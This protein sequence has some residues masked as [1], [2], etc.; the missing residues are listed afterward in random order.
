M[1]VTGNIGQKASPAM[2]MRL[3]SDKTVYVCVYVN[4]QSET[5]KCTGVLEDKITEKSIGVDALS[6]NGIMDKHKKLRTSEFL[7]QP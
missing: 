4:F 6:I 1:D 7:H 3:A 2:V 5:V